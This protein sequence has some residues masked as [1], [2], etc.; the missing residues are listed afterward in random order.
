MHTLIDFLNHGILPF[1]G[2]A[3]EIESL[4]S[5]WRGTSEARELR[6]ALL[7]G[8]AGIGKSRLLA[9]TLPR[10]VSSGGAVVHARLYPASTLSVV[11]V[12]AGALWSSEAGRRLLREEPAPDPGSVA[13]ALRRLSRLRPTLLVIEDIHLLRGDALKELGVLLG[14]VADETLSLLCVARP[15][16]LEVRPLLERYLTEEIR[17]EGLRRGELLGLI[18]TMFETSP[19]DDLVE[20]LLDRTLGNP[21]ALRSALRGALKSGTLVDGVG[22]WGLTVPRER[23]SD[24]LGQSVGLLSEGLAA[25]LAAD[26]REA[27]GQLATLGE[28]F[29][30]EA[31][32]V[33]IDAADQ[34]IERLVFKGIIV[35]SPLASEPLPGAHSGHPLLVFTHTL[36]H[37]FCVEHA[38]PEADRLIRVAA[39]EL[40]VYSLLPFELLCGASDT[41]A[42]TVE[43]IDGAIKRALMIAL[44][45]DYTASWEQAPIFLRA[46]EHLAET[47]RSRFDAATHHRIELALLHNRLSLGRRR[48]DGEEFGE[49]VLRMLAMTNDPPTEEVARYRLASLCRLRGVI[50]RYDHARSRE[51]WRE[52]EDLVE[53]FPTLLTSLPYIYFLQDAANA[54][55][56]VADRELLDHVEERLASILERREVSEEYRHHAL[57]RVWPFFL[58]LFDTPEGLHRRRRMLAEGEAVADGRDLTFLLLKTAFLA[59]TGEVEE[60]LRIS[61]RSLPLYLERGMLRNFY[62]GKVYQL[63][64]RAAFGA[65]LEGLEREARELAA[66]ASPV[67]LPAFRA[68][69]GE[70]FVDVG[71]LRGDDAWAGRMRAEFLDDEDDLR[72]MQ[73]VM[74]VLGGGAGSLG[75]VV[76]DENEPDVGNLLGLA[77]GSA[78]ADPDAA[79]REAEGVLKGPTLRLAEL[80]AVGAVVALAEECGRGSA[81]EPFVASLGA[82][83]AG[84][85]GE[86]LGWLEERE[87]FAYMGPMIARYGGYLSDGEAGGWRERAAAIERRQASSARPSD[88]RIAIS[89]LGAITIRRPGGEAERL[90]GGRSCALLG[91][92]IA[93]EML[94]KPLAHREFCI[95]ATGNEEEPERARKSLNKAVQRLREAIG[96]DAILTDGETPRLNRALVQVDLLDAHRLVAEAS[97]AARAD[98][99]MRAVPPLRCALDLARDVPFPSLYE[100]FFEAAREDFELRLRTAVIEV[101]GALLREGD[102]GGAEELLA[103]ATG[104]MPGDDELAGMLRRSLVALGRNTDAERIRLQASAT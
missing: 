55:S 47:F 76:A 16:E 25:D 45:L 42:H 11:P 8:E 22:G 103:A 73:A 5:F 35:P 46:A 53:R 15:V 80:V 71:L 67:L 69:V 78:G 50:Q 43:E 92:L 81:G 83:I 95:I 31:A 87:L 33:M 61:D 90:R 28:V 3:R 7:L 57:T 30:R 41:G 37:R 62:T 23:F 19:G 49:G 100:D 74:L 32:R 44:K 99:L 10:I 54:A 18:A 86:M 66:T 104:S 1:A 101:A 29:S 82:E 89:M 68:F 6:A 36:V 58:L 70:S 60:V 9:E 26:E 13:A 98:L 102:P 56:S 79:R 24:M 96:H 65:P 2:R 51:S 38:T 63:C 59:R 34:M 84:R 91:L 17:L 20:P 21:L 85:V 88:E 75:R 14:S 27:A 52:A 94:E 77:L 64:A 4:L 39:R 72:G 97:A 48:Y 12:I 93:D 40:P